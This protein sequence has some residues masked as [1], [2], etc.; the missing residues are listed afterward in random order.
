LDVEAGLGFPDLSGTA[1]QRK[2]TNAMLG[3]QNIDH[4]GLRIGDKDRSVAFYE[5]LGFKLI[6]DV[7]FEN[8]HP[9]I[10]IHPS[11]VVFNLLGPATEGRGENILMD[12]AEKHPGYTHVALK[13]ES[14]EDAESFLQDRSIAITGRHT[15]KGVN[16]VFIR[17]P[18]RNVIELVGPGLTVADPIGEPLP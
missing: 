6:T 13:L 2:R 16:T 10:M 1:L 17:D 8:G 4:V 5:T 15:F 12:V 18:D 11:G 3:I 9:I 7:G 14:A